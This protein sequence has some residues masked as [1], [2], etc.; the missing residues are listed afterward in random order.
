M[1]F[2]KKLFLLY[3]LAVFLSMTAFMSFEARGA[4]QRNPYEMGAQ[5]ASIP[6][7]TLNKAQDIIK[8]QLAAISARDAEAAF[9]FMSPPAHDDFETASDFLSSMRFEYGPIY[10]HM[11]MK[12][13]SHFENG[14][15][16]V[17]KVSLKDRYSAESVTVIYKLKL[18]DNGAWLIDSF[19]VL[20]FGE[21]QPI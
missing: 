11:D 10:N 5:K 13:L 7:E 14:A 4:E 18:Q 15:T 17:Q 9:D 21:A 3:F 1:E 8:K 19:T 2:H 16:T 12:F 20:D 6:P